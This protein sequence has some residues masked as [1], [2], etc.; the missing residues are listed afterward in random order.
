MYG[1]KGPLVSLS[2]NLIYKTITG[3]RRITVLCKHTC[4]PIPDGKCKNVYRSFIYHMAF[5]LA[6]TVIQPSYC[7]IS[8]RNECYSHIDLE[9]VGMEESMIHIEKHNSLCTHSRS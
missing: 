1:V 8:V 7:D 6:E 9:A 5:K 4:I 3:K 2:L